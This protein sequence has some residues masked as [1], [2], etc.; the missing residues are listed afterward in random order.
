MIG[1]L[2]ALLMLVS[3]A[4]SQHVATTQ[5]TPQK[6]GRGTDQKQTGSQRVSKATVQTAQGHPTDVLLKGSNIAVALFTGALAVLAFL[7]WRAMSKQAE[8]MKAALAISSRQSAVI[9]GQLTAMERQTAHMAESLIATQAAAEA[10]STSAKAL[11]A[12]ER[13]WILPTLD[14]PAAI[15]QH[16]ETAKGSYEVRPTFLNYGKT[17]ARV[18]E[19]SIG[20][21]FADTEGGLPPE[22]QY[23]R[24]SC[25]QD[26]LI[27]PNGTF[28]SIT[29]RIDVPKILEDKGKHIWVYGFIT[30]KDISGVERQT[31]FCFNFARPLLVRGAV[32]SSSQYAFYKSGPP[33]Y[34]R[35]E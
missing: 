30:Y 21:H 32:D 31:R 20:S 12:A 16:T 19:T 7:Q 15:F 10:A 17:H 26:I 34:N 28:C 23:G 13:A 2:L 29:A 22:P 35:C 9:E 1:R 8:H 6:P 3:I 14:Q 24:E 27:P 4:Y 25:A 5:A 11:I 33:A 18:I